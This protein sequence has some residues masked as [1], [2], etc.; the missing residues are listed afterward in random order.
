M[1]SSSSSRRTA[2]TSRPPRTRA[3]SRRRRRRRPR[4][5]SQQ[6]APVPSR[7]QE[8]LVAA[9]LS[10]FLGRYAPPVIRELLEARAG[11]DYEL[12]AR[13]INPQFMRVLK[14]IGFNRV[15]ARAEG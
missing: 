13:T 14:T 6:V 1:T 2:T 5:R 10:S 12:Y 3:A 4:E 15:W 8:S 9:G 7:T 11:D